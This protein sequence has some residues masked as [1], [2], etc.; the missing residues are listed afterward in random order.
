[1][2]IDR[3]GYLSKQ[4]DLLGKICAL[5]VLRREQEALD[6]FFDRLGNPIKGVGK[7][8]NVLA[9]EGGDEGGVDRL[10]DLGAD[11]FFL[12]A[13]LDEFVG[14]VGQVGIGGQFDK[15]LDAGAGLFRAGFEEIKKLVFLAVK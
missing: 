4:I 12:A 5:N 11:L 8:L 15:R 2:A 1:M 9:F 14:Q 10:G 7:I 13:R 6:K 3:V